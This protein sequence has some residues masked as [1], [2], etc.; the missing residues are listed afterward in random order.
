MDVFTLALILGKTDSAARRAEEAAG[1][2]EEAAQVAE[3]H[4]YG[5][6]VDDDD[7]II[8]PPEEGE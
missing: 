7:L 8:T 2:A 1:T 5:I 6:A 3:T 4:N